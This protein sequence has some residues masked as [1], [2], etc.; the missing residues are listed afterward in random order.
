[1]PRRPASSAESATRIP[2]P[3]SPISWAAGSRAP[4]KSTCVVTSQARPIFFSGAPKDIP[5]VSAGTTN[6]DSPRL[7]SS[8]VRANRM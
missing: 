8:E 6:A 1:M 5:G 2:C 3:S 4:S 7:A